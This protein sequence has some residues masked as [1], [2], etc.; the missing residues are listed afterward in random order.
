MTGHMLRTVLFFWPVQALITAALL[1]W[2]VCAVRSRHGQLLMTLASLAW[3]WI[4][5]RHDFVI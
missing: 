4:Q 5:L 3:V 2:G 1:W